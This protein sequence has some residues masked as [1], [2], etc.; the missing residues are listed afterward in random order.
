MTKKMKTSAR[1]WGMTNTFEGHAYVTP[2]GKAA[3]VKVKTYGHGKYSKG[4]AYAS[5]KQYPKGLYRV[6]VSHRGIDI[7]FY[8]PEGGVE[9]VRPVLAP[10]PVQRFA[11]IFH[12][13][14]DCYHC[15]CLQSHL[16][17]ASKYSMEEGV[18]LIEA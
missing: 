14:A 10:E 8:P 18:P 3:K 15:K 1:T 2:E 11:V 9:K 16:Q 4:S 7:K 12:G 17:V 6:D 5:T 13:E